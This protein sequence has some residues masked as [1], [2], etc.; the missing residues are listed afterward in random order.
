MRDNTLLVKRRNLISLIAAC[1]LAAGGC[2]ANDSVV[3]GIHQLS[4]SNGVATQG[5]LILRN[6]CVMLGLG[7]GIPPEMLA[8]PQGFTAE[9]TDTGFR[10]IDG[11]GRTVATAGQHVKLGGGPIGPNA[12]RTA[13]GGELPSGCVTGRLFAVDPESVP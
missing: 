4:G 8:W 5:T 3:L 12:V 2:A 7:G 11:E 6:G 10:V 13:E 9:A 1:S